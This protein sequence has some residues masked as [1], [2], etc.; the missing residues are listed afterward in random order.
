MSMSFKAESESRE[1]ASHF[2]GENL[3][4]ERKQAKLKGS[5]SEVDY[6]KLGL[7]RLAERELPCGPQN[8]V[9]IRQEHVLIK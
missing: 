8:K 9:K 4:V 7:F 3:M 6:C 1:P 5:T 2:A